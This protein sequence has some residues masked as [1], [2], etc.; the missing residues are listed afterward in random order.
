LIYINIHV[1]QSRNRQLFATGKRF[2]AD[3]CDI[4]TAA[5]VASARKEAGPIRP[6]R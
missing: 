4:K 5:C 6:R 2:D 1:F 3:F